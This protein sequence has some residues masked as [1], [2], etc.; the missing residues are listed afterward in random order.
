M[1]LSYGIVYTLVVG[2]RGGEKG[3]DCFG[4]IGQLIEVVKQHSQRAIT[5]FLCGVLSLC[6]TSTR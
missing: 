2:E 4:A 1:G 3:K 5:Y 6:R